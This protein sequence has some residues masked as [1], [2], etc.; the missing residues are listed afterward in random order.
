MSEKAFELNNVATLQENQSENLPSIDYKAAL[1]SYTPDEQKEITEL[2]EKID[3]SEDQK[4]MAYGSQPLVSS[5]EQ[6]GNLLKKEQGSEADQRVMKEVRELSNMVNEK[7][8]D[9]NKILKEPGFFEKLFLSLS[10]EKKKQKNKK[11]HESAITS[12]KL[13]MQLNSSYDSWL[14]MLRDAMFQI[15]SLSVSERA[16]TE[17]L[18][19]YIVAGYMASSRMEQLLLEKKEQYDKSGGLV[20]YEQEYEDLKDGYELFSRVLERLEDSRFTNK[21]VIGEYKLTERNNRKI[22]ES[23]FAQKKHGML[24]LA[25]QLGI[26]VLDAKNREVLEATQSVM[27]LTDELM[28]KVA[29]NIA[30]TAQ[31]SKQLIQIGFYSFSAAKESLNVILKAFDEE[32]KANEEFRVKNRA[33]LI[34]GAKMIEQL[35][36]H[37]NEI[38]Q[39]DPQLVASATQTTKV[40]STSE[41]AG[42]LQF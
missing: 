42:G 16:N 21:L 1:A 33:E 32:K 3:V 35:E 31:E 36:A 41:S 27:R 5:F 23:I 9:F 20:K 28:K 18:E 7:F 15:T 24:L 12:Y 38:K 22:Q 13:L 2:A 25:Q 6:V 10:A 19:K 40:T 26:A 14:D 8:E 30:L 4:V 29:N 11:L 34:E 39:I 17:T 37:I